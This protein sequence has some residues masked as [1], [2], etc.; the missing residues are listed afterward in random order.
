MSALVTFAVDLVV[1]EAPGQ[2]GDGPEN[3]QEEADREPQQER[4]ALPAADECRR[5]PTEEADDNEAH[6]IH[7]GPALENADGP[8][9]GDDREYGHDYRRK[10]GHDPD[11]DLEQDPR[12]DDE[13]ENRQ[14]PPAEVSSCFAHVLRVRPRVRVTTVPNAAV[15]KRTAAWSARSGPGRA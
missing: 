15:T 7:L 8:D 6:A 10:S 2:R 9:D 12:G 11:H 3:R 4:A 5:Q 14:H 1:L 13:H